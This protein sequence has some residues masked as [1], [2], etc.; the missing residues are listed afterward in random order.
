MSIW[1]KDISLE[2]FNEMGKNTAI[3]NLGIKITKIG[4][5]SLEGEMPIDKRTH[6]IHGILHGGSSVLFA[7]TLGSLA[8][9]LAANVGFT[10]VGLDINANHLRG[11]T[12]GNVIGIA[13]PIHIGRTTQVWEI[14]ISHKETKKMVCVSRLTV[15]V[16][17]EV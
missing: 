16:I 8:G 3:E 2:E 12:D 15:A 7:E 9:V 17:K 6:Q 1:N 11:F 10:V 14:E 5:N 13:T 4:K